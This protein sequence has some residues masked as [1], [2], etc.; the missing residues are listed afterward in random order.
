VVKSTL[1]LVQS[2]LIVVKS[3]LSLVQSTLIVVQ[4]TLIAVQ[5]TLIVDQSTLIAVQRTLIVD[6]STLIAVQS[7]LIAVQRTLIVVQSTQVVDQ[8]TM[9]AAQRAGEAR[10]RAPGAAES[11]LMGGQERGALALRRYG[12]AGEGAAWSAVWQAYL[13]DRLEV[14]RAASLELGAGE[15]GSGL[16]LTRMIEGEWLSRQ[17][18]ETMQV[19]DWLTLEFPDDESGLDP[20]DLARLVQEGCDQVAADFGWEHGAPTWVTVLRD[21]ADAPWMP[22][23][24]GYCV[25]KVPF[26]KVCLPV[27]LTDDPE[28]LLP[29][30]R[31][32]Y[33]HVMAHV[34]SDGLAPTWL[35]EAVAMVADGERDERSWRRLAGGGAAWLAPDE[36]DLAFLEDRESGAGRSAVALAYAQAHMVGEW[37][38]AR[39]RREAL[40]RVLDALREPGLWRAVLGRLTG[41]RPESR[42]FREVLGVSVEEAFA[43]ARR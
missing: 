29:A 40:G 7:T 8:R 41:E 2:T 24:H 18:S 10:R 12:G 3:T 11:A 22:M 4:S 9:V 39:H 23:R 31:H 5:R 25:D 16:D 20:E 36:L 30:V 27:Y 43:A 28:E 35:D 42:A 32:E 1:S 37:V 15:F 34:R 6:Q 14:A 21:E 38:A 19:T 17:G 33:A 26:D 13:M